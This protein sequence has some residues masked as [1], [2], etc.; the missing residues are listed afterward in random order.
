VPSADETE[1][2]IGLD[3]YADGIQPVWLVATNLG[4]QPARV[5]LVS[6]DPEYFSP[7]E[8]A[9]KY[10]GKFSDE[11]R[12]DMERW[13]Y[14]HQMPRRIPPGETR[15]G[16]VMTHLASGTKGFNVD[17][18]TSAGSANFTFFV[19]IPGFRAD[20]MDVDFPHLYSPEEM[21]ELS[22]DDLRQALVEFPCCSTDDSGSANG[23][24]F[25]VILVGSPMAVRR[26][27]L[28]GGWQETSAGS[29]DTI[30]A[31]THRYRGRQPDGTFHKSRPDGAE[32]KELRLWLT[33]MSADG[34]RV[35]AGQVS[36]DLA[37]NKSATSFEDY[38]IDPDIDDARMFVMQ[39][40]WYSQSLAQ[41]GF[42]AGSQKTTID[43]PQE[44][45]H[46]SEYFSDGMRVVL[47][48][49]ESPVALDD[50]VILQWS[51]FGE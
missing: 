24:P 48:V 44:N 17:V 43:S 3:L 39:N 32:R 20:F 2:L 27:L 30:L 5:A 34:Q 42:V 41:I 11:G 1:A 50:T 49:S 46:K 10:R 51:R 26:T 6:V 19:A 38:R 37:G 9:W 40:V 45:F 21:Q 4:E 47:F 13:F 36:Y 25:N 31:R 12:A 14:E 23:D 16:F 15:S 18:Y 8:V 33:P 28:R 29:P 35:W 7:L 22:Q